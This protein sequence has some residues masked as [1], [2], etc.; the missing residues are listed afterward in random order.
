MKIARTGSVTSASITDGSI[1]N[2]DINASAA[3]DLSKLANVSATDKVLGRASA[4]AG[5]IEEISCT[6]AGRSLIAGASATA[7]KVT[8]FGALPTAYTQTYATVTRTHSNPVASS[9]ATTS[10]TNVTPWG[11]STQAQADN[12][13][14]AVNNLITDVANVK[15]VLNQVIDDLQ[16][17]GLLQ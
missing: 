17:A 7:Q 6:A 8:L 2:A 1:T 9:V 12:I 15:Q 16:A 4:G 11:Y 3:I 13:R 5:A 10:A 14:A